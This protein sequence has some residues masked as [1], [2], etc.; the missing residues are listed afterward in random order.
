MF[1]VR[2]SSVMGSALDRCF[3]LVCEHDAID[4]VLI[5][6]DDANIHLEELLGELARL[7]AENDQLRLENDQLWSELQKLRE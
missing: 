2:C 6:D 1:D 5:C 3:D 4:A 7:R